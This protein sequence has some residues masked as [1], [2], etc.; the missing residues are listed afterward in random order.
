MKKV[1][2]HDVNKIFQEALEHD[3][4]LMI[5]Q[6]EWIEEQRLFRKP[7]LKQVFSIFHDCNPDREPYQARQQASGSGSKEVVLAYLY[8]IINGSLSRSRSANGL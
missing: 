4:S 6:S 2:D 5:R 7:K 3:K 8:G 1:I